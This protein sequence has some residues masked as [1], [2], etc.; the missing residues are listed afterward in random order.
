MVSSTDSAKLFTLIDMGKAMRVGAFATSGCSMLE[1]GGF[2]KQEDA[3]A[4]A[5]EEI[6]EWSALHSLIAHLDFW[7]PIDRRDLAHSFPSANPTRFAVII[8]ITCG[9]DC[10][11]V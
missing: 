3:V 1:F 11:G 7:L 4:A 6:A 5:K 10:Q 2:L 9:G 8:F